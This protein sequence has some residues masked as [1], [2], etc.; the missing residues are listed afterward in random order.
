MSPQCTHLISKKLFFQ[1]AP[2]SH[3]Y[4]AQ[5]VT[6]LCFYKAQWQPGLCF[7]KSLQSPGESEAHK[8]LLQ[9]EY[10]QGQEGVNPD[11]FSSHPSLS[12]SQILD[13]CWKVSVNKTITVFP[14]INTMSWTLKV[15]EAAF[16]ARRGES[17]KLIGPMKPK[18][19]WQ[20]DSLPTHHT[21]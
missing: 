18:Q 12:T 3:I 13:S 6:L 8:G 21:F 20:V 9:G 4:S 14:G 19:L 11:S 16:R 1:C 2:T 17:R 15:S 5:S 10:S 7:L